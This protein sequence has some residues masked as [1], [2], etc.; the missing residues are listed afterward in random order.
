MGCTFDDC[1]PTW[2]HLMPH[3]VTLSKS[4]KIAKHQVTQR[5]WVAVMGNNPSFTK[6]D[7]LPVF[8]V[9]W[10]DAQNFITRLNSITGK[11]YRL[12]TEAEWEYA[13]RGGNKSQGFKYSGSNNVDEV[14][15]HS[16]N[17]F[18]DPHPVGT[19]KANELGIYDM[20][21]NM[22]EWVQDWYAPFTG[23]PQTD[24]QGPP[25]GTDRVARGAGY[26]NPAMSQAVMIRTYI[27]PTGL[28]SIG[29]RLAHP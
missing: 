6:G 20:S 22:W 7:N 18:G 16:G 24:P 4:Y 28:G 21:G 9:S 12:P 14:A 8:G 5:Q 1:D 10:H 19:K 26:T 15:W 25:N 27:P 13:T 29:F 17:S 11:N 23:E 3:Q 2:G